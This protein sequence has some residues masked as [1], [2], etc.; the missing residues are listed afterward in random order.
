MSRPVLEGRP[1]TVEVA[2][3]RY[4]YARLGCRCDDCREAHRDYCTAKTADL[5]ARLAAEFDRLPHGSVST[6]GNWGCRCEPCTAAQ[7]EA[8]RAAYIRRAETEAAPP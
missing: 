4:A 7:S 5:R 6:Y 8:N 2:P 3:S 1:H